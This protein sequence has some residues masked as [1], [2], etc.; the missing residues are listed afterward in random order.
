MP[1]RPNSRWILALVL[2]LAPSGL[3]QGA[4][5]R[6]DATPEVVRVVDREERLTLVGLRGRDGRDGSRG[7]NG[8]TGASGFTDAR[9]PKAGGRGGRGGDGRDGEDGARGGNGPD[10]NLWM[11]LEPG[12][13]R[14]LRVR[15]EAAGK[16]R[17]YSLD[18]SQASLSVQ[19]QGGVGGRGGRGGAGGSGGRGGS[20]RPSGLSGS[21]G[22]RGLD[23]HSGPTG[24]GGAI[25][26]TVTPEAK[27]FL[28]V[29]HPSSQ[30]G[31][32]PVIQEG[33]WSF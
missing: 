20:G 12:E 27:P 4:T 8:S 30:G 31:P 6:Q 26:V 29:L 17:V 7:G 3:G 19:T 5:P 2:G 25:R 14:W 28:G 15:V 33:P 11:D 24:R 32:E 22:M 9:H 13:G 1:M 10:V 21:S 18:P 16:I 23:G